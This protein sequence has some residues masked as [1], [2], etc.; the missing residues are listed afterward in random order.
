[1]QRSNPFGLP[2]RPLGASLPCL[3]GYLLLSELYAVIRSRVQREWC[4]PAAAVLLVRPWFGPLPFI[5]AR[6]AFDTGTPPR[7][8]VKNVMPG[9][10]CR[11]F[12]GGDTSKP[13]DSD[14]SGV[15][16]GVRPS[17]VRDA[18][19]TGNRSPRASGSPA[20]LE[21]VDGWPLATPGTEI[22]GGSRP[23]VSAVRRRDPRGVAL[24]PRAICRS[25][26]PSAR[27]TRREHL[28]CGLAS[29][30]LVGAIGW[31]PA[32][33]PVR[34]GCRDGR[35]LSGAPSLYLNSPPRVPGGFGHRLGSGVRPRSPDG[36]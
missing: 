1:M 30:G 7:G 28:R 5:L 24:H 18:P 6:L 32:S 26:I 13:P 35:A 21:S 11:G 8:K 9:L 34:R 12:V 25:P 20:P 33:P 19:R 17:T 3:T 2:P 27:A 36:A 15:R 10:R 4:P 29:R 31:S 22:P 14:L 23:V 16:I